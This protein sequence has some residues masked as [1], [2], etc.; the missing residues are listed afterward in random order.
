[1]R[2]LPALQSCPGPQ[3]QGRDLEPHQQVA[4]QNFKT[5][6][7]FRQKV[8][9]KYPFLSEFHSRA[10][11]LYAGLLKGDPSVIS[12]IPPTQ[13]SVVVTSLVPRI[14]DQVFNILHWGGTEQAAVLPAEL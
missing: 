9:F 3:A 6:T 2:L 4:R 5:A 13:P 14:L 7:D 1:M 8:M 11:C 12:Y 10:E